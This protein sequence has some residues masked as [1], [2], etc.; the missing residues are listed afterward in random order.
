MRK[1]EVG[2]RKFGGR[3][4]GRV[5]EWE[6][7]VWGGVSAQVGESKRNMLGSPQSETNPGTRCWAGATHT[8]SH[9]TLSTVL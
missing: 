9:S 8:F 4:E 7:G 5:S 3:Q 6:V 2:S 1:E